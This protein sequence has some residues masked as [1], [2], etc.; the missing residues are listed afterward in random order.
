MPSPTT[1]QDWVTVKTTLP[2]VPYPPIESRTPI[3]TERLLIRPY[4]ESDAEELYSVLRSQPEVMIFTARGKV[5]ESVEVTRKNIQAR[6]P[7]N[8]QTNYDWIICST[9]TEELIGIGGS[10]QRVCDLGWPALGYMFR[11]NAWGK[12]YGT[13]FANA[14]LDAW[15]KLPREEFEV[16]V[17]RDTIGEGQD[18][19]VVPECIV[20]ITTE[21]NKASQ[22]VM[23]K[24]GMKLVKIWQTEDSHEGGGLV[25]L[26][27]FAGTSRPGT[28]TD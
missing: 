12:G 6:L 8:D 13:E 2:S 28:A 19:D 5:D 26:Y 18:G 16:K 23:G 4:R 10:H 17:D 22:H 24:A 21:E 20:G 15:W 27:V 11:K 7:P 3:K 1:T 25:D 9:E 14:L